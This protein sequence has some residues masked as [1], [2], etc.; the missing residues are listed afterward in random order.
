MFQGLSA[1]IGS[2]IGFAYLY[3][4]IVATVNFGIK[5]LVLTGAGLGIVVPLWVV[6]RETFAAANSRLAALFMAFC[7]LLLV[8]AMASDVTNTNL[9]QRA[10]HSWGWTSLVL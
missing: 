7:V 6:I 4:V 5:G 2:V 10:G 1:L 9:F 8:A 3:L